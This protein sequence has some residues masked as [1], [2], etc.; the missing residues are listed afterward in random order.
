MPPPSQQLPNEIYHRLYWY[1]KRN[2]DPVRIAAALNLPLKTVHNFITR[3]KTEKGLVSTR[4]P[5]APERSKPI[6][7]EEMDFLDIF[8][9]SKTRHSIFDIRG[10]IDKKNAGKLRE[11]LLKTKSSHRNP[12]ALKMTDVQHIDNSG[13]ETILSLSTEFKQMGRYFAI[14]DPS[15]DIEPLLKQ[16]GIDAKI[17][18]FGTEIAFEEHAFH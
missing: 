11:M 3:L 6:S 16:Y 2:V 5:P 7:T 17:P 4:R 15:P 12:I 9:F 8:V 1:M 18:I 14:L 10:S 13:A